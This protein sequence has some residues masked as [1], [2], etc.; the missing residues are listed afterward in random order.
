MHSAVESAGASVDVGLR[1][2][3]RV[4]IFEPRGSPR[5]GGWGMRVLGKLIRLAE[6]HMRGTT[7]RQVTMLSTVTATHRGTVR[8]DEDCGRGRKPRYIGL[9]RKRAWVPD[10]RSGLQ[11]HPHHRP[12][13]PSRLIRGK[14]GPAPG[15]GGSAAGHDR[16]EA[17][18]RPS[19]GS[20]LDPCGS[21]INT[22]LVQLHPLG[23]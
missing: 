16:G 4:L 7:T 22:L 19:F 21:N 9:Q 8:L 5:Q 3:S 1:P 12:E 14:M 23:G 15:S 11:P 17:S 2:L 13:R 6:I 10:D 20:Y 18:H